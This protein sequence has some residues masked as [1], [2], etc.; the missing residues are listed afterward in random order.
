MLKR[1]V[2][3]SLIVLAVGG[4]AQPTLAGAPSVVTHRGTFVDIGNHTG[5]GTA[6]VRRRGDVR[7]LHLSANFAT[8]MRVIRL[9]MYLATDRT[10]KK[11]IDLGPMKRRGAQTFRI[12]KGVRLSTYQFAFAWCV[13]ANVPITRA[14]LAVVP[15]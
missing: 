3:L 15:R 13:P 11:F 1:L 2:G 14:R 4:A 8:D 10:G 12:P 5:D 6:T 7:T 9:H